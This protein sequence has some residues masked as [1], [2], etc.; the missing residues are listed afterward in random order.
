MN[1]PIPIETQSPETGVKPQFLAAV[2]LGS[3]SFHMV[4]ARVEDGHLHILDRLKEMVRLG[5][6]LDE[7]GQLSEEARQRAFACLARFGERVK[8]L[9]R[10]SVA[11]V[12]TNTLRQSKNSRAFLRKARKALGHPIS[13]IAGREEARLIYLGVSHSLVDEDGKRFV[14][15]IGGG[16]T[17][18]IIGEHFEPQHLE[19]LSMGCVSISRRFFKQGNLS[20]FCWEAANTAAHLQLRPINRRYRKIGWVSA[21]GASGTIRAVAK[22][23]VRLELSPYGITLDNLY[24]IR[25]RM[26]AAG[27]LDNLEL[28]GLKNDRKPV[29][30]G[31]LAVLIA[32]FEALK[33]DNMQVSDGALRE[34]LI[35]E[36]LGR[37]RSE[38]TRVKTISSIQQRFQISQNHAR[39]ISSTAHRLFSHCCEAWEFSLDHAELLHWACSLHEIGL[40][41]SHN[42]YHKH[43]AYLLDHA[44][45]AG[46]SYQE[47]AWMSVLVRCHRKKISKKLL[48]QVPEEDQSTILRLAVLL[49]L[50]TLLHRSRRDKIAEIAVFSVDEDQITLQFRQGELQQRP[51]LLASLEKQAVY[52]CAVNIDLHYA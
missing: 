8:G 23:V 43:S 33:I 7:D 25:D 38:D 18:L 6:G 37:I 27:T 4:V 50:A 11:A 3:N 24:Q 17:E 31:G 36:R 32:T 2:D 14:M 22:V 41:I 45:L 30:A 44:D 48:A 19:S 39:R 46:F 51:L 35:Y 29:F 52:L 34:G 21:T 12:G 15:D 16:S 26:I 42:S 1:K 40:A 28:A 13:I 49:R 9:P 10:G 20:R 47:Q 5:A